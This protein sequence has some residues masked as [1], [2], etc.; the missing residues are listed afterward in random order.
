MPAD[1]CHNLH[2]LCKKLS[3]SNKQSITEPHVY[4]ILPRVH[5]HN[6]ILYRK[7]TRIS[8]RKW[9][10]INI[11]QTKCKKVPFVN[12]IAIWVKLFFKIHITIIGCCSACVK[13]VV[14]FGVTWLYFVAVCYLHRCMHLTKGYYLCFA[15]SCCSTGHVCCF[16]TVY[17]VTIAAFMGF[18]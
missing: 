6:T 2:I 18:S 12:S 10:N 11:Y 1:K 3:R 5:P 16:E 13:N 8:V 14:V 9:K 4:N 7:Y 15:V 17:F